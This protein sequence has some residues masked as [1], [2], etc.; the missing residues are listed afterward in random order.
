MKARQLWPRVLKMVVV[1]LFL[2]MT[3]LVVSF[4]AASAF[5]TPGTTS[6]REISAA[7]V[8]AVLY[9]AFCQFWVAPKGRS[10]FWAKVPTVVASVVPL[11][12]GVPL[13]PRAEG[14]PWLAS[15]CLGSVIG[16]MVASRVTAT[17]QG[18]IARDDSSN[19]GRRCR[20]NLL[21]GFILLIAVAL[22]I[23]ISVILLFLADPNPRINAGAV[24]GFL[25]IT[26][27]FD[28]KAALVLGNALWRPRERDPSSKG[29]LGT[30]AFLALWLGLAYGAF[31]IGMLVGGL[32]PGLRIAAV[33]L[34][35]CA[36]CGLI[37]TALMT[38][39]SVIVDRAQLSNLT[40]SNECPTKE[41]MV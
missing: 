24:G 22:L 10:G 18:G 20:R 6:F 7:C 3:A 31:G 29:T 40:L 39:T 1:S 33:V 34:V 25:G 2:G 17:P 23:P 26:V 4:G 11:L 27:L 8:A 9:L 19:R 41:G 32:G 21:A 28:L 5:E 12:V 13:T 35:L 38:V 37:T 16:A 15:G 14:I 30:A 36:V